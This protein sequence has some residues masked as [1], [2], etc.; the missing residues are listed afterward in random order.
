MTP[1]TQLAVRAVGDGRL[2]FTRLPVRQPAK[3]Q[4]RIRVEA[5]GICRLDSLTV[6]GGFPGL[7]YPRVP[8]HEVVGRIEALG[9]GVRD[10]TIGERVAVGLLAGRCGHCAACV[11]GDVGSCAGVLVS[12][13]SVDG[14]YA[15]TMIAHQDALVSVTDG[16]DPSDVAPLLCSGVSISSAL[17]TSVAQAGDVVALCGV[18]AFGLLAL[19]FACHLGFRAVV[20][21]RGAGHVRTVRA[22]GAWRYVDA[23]AEDATAVL[24]AVG[25]AA[26][27]V[28]GASGQPSA[29][30]LVG[31]LQP[32]GE[33]VVVGTGAS[34]RLHVASPR[35]LRDVLEVSVAKK[36]RPLVETTSLEEAADAYARVMQTATRFLVVGP[37]RAGL[38]VFPGKTCA[39]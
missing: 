26:A 4:V 35:E 37:G 33:V 9:E 23:D 25:G 20:I 12:G 1:R 8:G 24:Q 27:I 6:E 3:S 17:K 28:S 32:G 29:S 2:E 19:Q 18:D 36:I 13:A 14:G 38:K 5:C 30:A 34:A 21:G 31:G 16:L 7:V 22:L 39:Y 15:E 10:Y 11:R